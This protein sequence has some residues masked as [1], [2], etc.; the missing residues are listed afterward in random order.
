MK[1]SS[2]NSFSDWV[3][4]F[5]SS[6]GI[7][8]LTREKLNLIHRNNPRRSQYARNFVPREMRGFDV[9]CGSVRASMLA[10]L[11][12]TSAERLGTGPVTLLLI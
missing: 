6:L 5:T 8:H 9:A 7:E 12:A 11:S 3:S 10:P 2:S 4:E 1:K